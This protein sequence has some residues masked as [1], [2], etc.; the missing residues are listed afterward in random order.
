MAEKTTVLNIRLTERQA[1]WLRKF[2]DAEHGGNLSAAVR[3]ALGEAWM[4][5]RCREEYEILREYDGFEIP[6]NEDGS[7]RGLEMFLSPLGASLD[8]LGDEERI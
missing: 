2:A 7:T 4:M 1:D 6:R 5:R 8:F 3:K